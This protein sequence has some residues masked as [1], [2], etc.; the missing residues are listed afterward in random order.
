MKLY[1]A[2][3]A[4][5]MAADIVL[6]ELGVPFTP[7]LV[8]LRTKKT[9]SGDDFTKVN[10]K[11]YVPALALD[12]GSVLTEA[13]TV[14]QYIADQKPESG[15]APQPGTME[16]YRLM[17]WIN[18]ISSEIHKG[19]GPLWNPNVSDDVRKAAT[20]QLGRRF[21]YVASALGAKPYLLGDTFTIADAYLF[22]ILGWSK[23]HKVDM[24][25]WPVLQAY[26]DRIAARPAVQATLKAE[27]LV[28]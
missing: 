7:E 25:P 22:T 17:E 18:F 1:Y 13:G 19:F 2:P 24:T 20:A 28:K 9:A 10:P 11:G 16:R 12:D 27:G 6:H 23:L 21:D 26:V 5:S 15:L 3:G 14:I 8:D 4:C